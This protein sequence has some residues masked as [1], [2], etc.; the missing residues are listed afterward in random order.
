MITIWVL[1]TIKVRPPCNYQCPTRL[2][3]ESSHAAN[4]DTHK[5]GTANTLLR[6]SCLNPLCPHS[7]YPGIPS[8][9]LCT[10]HYHITC[11][12]NCR[13]HAHTSPTAS[14]GALPQEIVSRASLGSDGQVHKC[15]LPAVAD[16]PDVFPRVP[17]QWVAAMIHFWIVAHCL[18]STVWNCTLETKQEGTQKCEKYQLKLFSF[19]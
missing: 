6:A 13:A 11:T 3:T 16:V 4:T 2:F 10:P 7:A 15:V 12:H 19:P 8:R 14:G 17:S 9:Q 5:S 1:S 18:K